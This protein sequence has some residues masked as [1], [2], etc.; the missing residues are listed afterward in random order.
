MS[1]QTAYKVIV[2]G[3]DLPAVFAA[4]RASAELGATETDRKVLLIVPYPETTCRDAEGVLRTEHLLGGIMTA[5][6]LNYWDDKE[7]AKG[8]YAQGSY[9][10]FKERLG[11]GFNRV[12]LSDFCKTEAEQCFVDVLYSADIINYSFG[13]NPRRILSVTVSPIAWDEE[14]RIVWQEGGEGVKYTADVFIDASTD[15]RLAGKVNSAC[16]VGRYDWPNVYLPRDETAAKDLVGRQQAATLMVKMRLPNPPTKQVACYPGTSRAAALWTSSA[17]YSRADGAIRAFNERWSEKARLMIKPTNAA[18]DGQDSDEWWVNGLLLFDVDGRAHKRDN[19][20]K[21]VFKVTPR[22]GYRTT[23]DAR[24]DARA[25]LRE[26]LEE[27]QNAFRAFDGFADCELVLDDNGEPVVGDVLYIRESVHM[28]KV[29]N[30]RTHGSETN[31][32]VTK[33]EARKAGDAPRT[34]DDA[35]NYATRIGLAKYN[36]D[37]HPYQ[38][39]DLIS[40]DGDYLWGMDSAKKMRADAINPKNP[41]Y[42]PIDAITTRFAANLLIPGYAAGI[43]SYAWGELRVFSH[44]SVLGDA[45]GIAAAYCCRQNVRPCELANSGKNMMAIQNSIRACQGRLEK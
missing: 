1:N 13:V 31:Y 16:T 32:S 41:L 25:F 9:R 19:D 38:S 12:A 40:A 8:L 23:D 39:S 36:C 11:L 35:E 17:E 18:R 44:L 27:V 34:G 10:R 4:A 30:A 5:G 45:A 22:Y 2:Y 3:G 42:I 33:N 20:A 6:G 7:D 15:G 37:L 21:T 29:K 43:S 14:R 26:N 24:H 28:A